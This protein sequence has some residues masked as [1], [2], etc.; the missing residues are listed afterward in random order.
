MNMVFFASPADEKVAGKE[1]AKLYQLLELPF[2]PPELREDGGEIEAAAAGSLPNL[3]D[4]NHIR[5]D[6]H[7]HTPGFRWTGTRSR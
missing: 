3:I 7:M 4:L 6:L 2:I 5:G 1:E